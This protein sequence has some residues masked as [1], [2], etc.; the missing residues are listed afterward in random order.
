MGTQATGSGAPFGLLGRTLGHSWSPRIHQTLGSAP[1]ALFEKEPQEVTDFVLHGSW[2]GLNVTIPY[3]R[4]VVR[5]ADETSDRVRRL[6]AA[7]TLVRH[8]DGTVY[9]DNTDVLGFSWMLTRFLRQRAGVEPEALRGRKALVLGSGGACQAVRAALEDV[10]CEVV[11]ISRTGDETYATL[12]ERHADACLL[13]NTTPVG[14]YPHCPAS[15]VDEQTLARL[16]GLVGVLDVVYNPER[17]GLCLMAE[18][19]GLPAESGL[20][21]LVSQAFFASQLFQDATLDEALVERIEA[22]IRHQTRNVAIIGMPGSGKTAAGRRLA[23]LA[24][25]PFVDLDDCFAVDVGMTAAEC[26]RTRGED[27]FRRLETQTASAYASRSGLVIACGGGIV[28]RPENYDIL[29]QNATVVMLDRHLDELLASEVGDRPL[30]QTKGV[31]RLAD[32]RMPLYRAWAD[33][34]LPCTGSAA[35]DALALQRILKL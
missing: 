34:V 19:L 8:A 33:V 7:N 14:M 2:R 1:Y 27:E 32:E 15:P 11:V 3:K 24:H 18:R 30:S 31:S 29:H 28:T 13:V 20:A 25:R 4:D 5:I 10:G 12:T 16:T 6:G 9:A 26:I 23:R 22:D 35:G 17:T 21:M